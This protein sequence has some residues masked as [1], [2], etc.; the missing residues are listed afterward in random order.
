MI[1]IIHFDTLLEAQDAKRQTRQISHE[2]SFTHPQRVIVGT[3]VKVVASTQRRVL[4]T[5]VH[6][7]MLEVID[8]LT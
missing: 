1:I 4:L 7:Q 2:V 5:H 8:V 3:E 6:L